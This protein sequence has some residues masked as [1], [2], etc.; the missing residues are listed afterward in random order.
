MGFHTTVFRLIT[1]SDSLSI[2]Y[3][4]NMEYNLDWS[5]QLDK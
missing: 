1:K 3:L 5:E 2:V 4:L